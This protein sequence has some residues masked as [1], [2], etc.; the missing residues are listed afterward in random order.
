ME[1][2]NFIIKNKSLET[3]I[4]DIGEAFRALCPQDY[5]DFIAYVKTES[6][7]LLKPSGM[8][9]EGTMLNLM[10]IPCGTNSRGEKKNLY[11]FIKE[12]MWKR[13]HIDDF[14]RDR[15]NYRLLCK[16]WRDAEVKRK[17]TK[18]FRITPEAFKEQ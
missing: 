18:I 8:S 6:E 16:V 13:A 2:V 14:F 10:K 12:Q 11:G 4:E 1:A 9:H 5:E 3:V 7:I 17:P 15:E